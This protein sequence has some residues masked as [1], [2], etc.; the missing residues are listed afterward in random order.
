MP[1]RGDFRVYLAESL[2][3]KLQQYP[4]APFFREYVPIR[5][6]LVVTRGY[7]Y[8]LQNESLAETHLKI[9]KTEN[10]PELR[11]SDIPRETGG[12]T[13]FEVVWFSAT[14]DCV[15]A[16]RIVHQHLDKY[17]PNPDPSNPRLQQRRSWPGEKANS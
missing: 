10:E 7:I 17:R 16:E 9:G 3:S 4:L 2:P 13:P 5:A 15:E 12:P 1:L 11:A 8:I 6:L 14:D